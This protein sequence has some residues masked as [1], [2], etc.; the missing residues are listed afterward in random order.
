MEIVI[1]LLPSYHREY[2]VHRDT[3]RR[4]SLYGRNKKQLQNVCVKPKKSK[5]REGSER[6][7]EDKIRMI[8]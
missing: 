6:Q 1:D 8:F 4:R 7:D 2:R 3:G 5:G